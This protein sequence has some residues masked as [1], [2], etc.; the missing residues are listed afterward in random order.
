MFE[1]GNP[2]GRLVTFRAVPPVE[3][4]NTENAARDLRAIIVGI[5]GRVVVCSDVSEGRTFSAET[6]ARFIALMKSD[7]RKV[8]RSALLL[9]AA[10]PTF[11]LQMER[12]V[13]EAGN[14]ARR[15][16]LDRRELREWLR[17]VLSHEEQAALEAFLFF[18]TAPTA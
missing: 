7:N 14:P 10:S 12:M 11:Q 5:P 4:A 15:T 6:T 1:V 9:S 18:P 16:F 8:E 3:E 2:T 13:R 17:P